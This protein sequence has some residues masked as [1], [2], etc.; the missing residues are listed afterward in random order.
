MN[1]LVYDFFAYSNSLRDISYIAA[2][3]KNDYR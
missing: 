1:H 2:Q 3:A